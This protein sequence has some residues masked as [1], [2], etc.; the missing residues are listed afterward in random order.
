MGSLG[1][2]NLFARFPASIA[3]RADNVVTVSLGI[4]GARCGAIMFYVLL[5]SSGRNRLDCVDCSMIVQ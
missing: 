1:S 4:P 2:T 5:N 3:M